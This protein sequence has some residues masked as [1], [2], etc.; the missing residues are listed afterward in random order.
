M[1]ALESPQHAK[2]LLALEV[3]CLLAVLAVG[4]WM[5]G[6]WAHSADHV[7]WQPAPTPGCFIRTHEVNTW[8]FKT[9]IVVNEYCKRKASA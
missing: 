2:A 8:P 4:A 6:A 9:E 1:S 5:V 7:R 3:L